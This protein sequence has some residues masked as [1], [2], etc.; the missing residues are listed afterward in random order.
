MTDDERLKV[1]RYVALTQMKGL[2]PVAQNALLTAAGD[3]QTCFEMSDEELIYAG[4]IKK[5]ARNRISSK[6]I[7]LFIRQREDEAL[8]ERAE[9]I[10][11]FS[12]TSAIQVIVRE[13]MEYPGRFK[14]LEDMPILLY[15][16][17]ELRIN[18]FHDSIGIVG[19]RRCSITGKNMAIETAVDAALKGKAIISG[20]AKGIDSYAHTAA[21]KSKGYTIAVLGNGVDICYPKEHIRLYEEIAKHGCILSEYSPGTIP[22]EYYFPKRNRLIAALSDRLCVIDTGRNSGTLS[23]V[24]NARK[25]G[26]EVEMFPQ[27]AEGET[28]V[29]N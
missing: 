26:R 21:L 25:Y 20:M 1:L 13:D 7:E 14:N 29:R 10:L 24:E 5:S 15:V 18:E 4:K 11:R 12:E 23:T 22:R 27:R 3:I 2:G 6:R 28:V 16:K 8:W 9:E 19:A 17:G